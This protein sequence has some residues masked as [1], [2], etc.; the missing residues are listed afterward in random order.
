MKKS[1][2]EIDM[3]NGSIMDKLITFSLPLM[4]TSILQ[5]MFNA[6]DIIVVGRFTNSQA[7]AAVGSTTA[8]INIFTNLFIG[9]SMGANVLAA[10]YY[11]AGRDREMSEVVHTSVAVALISGI[12]MAFVG[13][14]MAGWALEL[15]A[16]PQDVIHLSTTYMK[17]YFLGMP[18]FMLYN[19]GAA[20]LRAVGD[21]RRPLLFLALSGMANV[22]LDLLLVIVIPLGVAG[23]AIGTVTSQ[24]ISSILVLRCLC[25]S[26][27]SYQLHFSKLA[28]KGVHLKRI[29]QVGIP[30]GIQTTVINFSNALLQS[31][32]NSFG[33]T[34]MAGYTAANNIIGFLYAAVNAVTQA[35]MSF[36]SQNYG[37]R[38]TKRMDRVLLDCMVLSVGVSAVLGI[39]AYLFGGQLL[40]IYTADG[41]VIQCG[42]EI[43]S[44]TTVPYFLC[45]IMDLLPGA[46]RGMG[47]SAV[48]MVLS[49]IGTVGTRIV[50]I[51]GFF[52]H[53]RSLYF[54][55]IS[56]PGSWIITIIMQGIC[57]MMVRKACHRKLNA[58][59]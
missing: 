18:F 58:A 22:V 1:K 19:Y 3:C 48:T 7:L 11:A 36:T 10:R 42:L 9:I 17:I 38:K 40:K 50:W 43:L 5:L 37:V 6:V 27:G 35:C 2:Y 29:F 25:R 33:A 51:Y 39:G 59:G 4:L 21:T 56:Y 30:A 47:Y 31:S 14:G 28:V 49:V 15:M 55:F 44:I 16:T 53:H 23:V 13:F 8:L 52:P 32:V 54:L 46:L 12:L 20:I 34:A 57:F 41:E 45:G 24:M 26:E